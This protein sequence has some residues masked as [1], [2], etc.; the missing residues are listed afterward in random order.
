MSTDAGR[1][2]IGCVMCN[3]VA[4]DRRRRGARARTHP[5]DDHGDEPLPLRIGA[6]HGR[7]GPARGRVRRPLRRRRTSRSRAAQV[8]ALR[9][10]R[11]AYSP[12]GVNVGANLGKAAGAGVP[13]HLHVHVLPRWNGD[14][15]FMTAVGRG[16]G[17]ARE[18]ADGLR[19]AESGV[20]RVAS[21]RRD[22]R[23]ERRLDRRFDRRPAARGSRRHRLRRA[24][25]VPRHQAPPDRGHDL[26][27]A[28]R[29]RVV[30]RARGYE[31]RPAVRRGPARGRSPRT[32]SSRDGR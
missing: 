5:R 26:P 22:R 21:D 29:A 24:V 11:A 8:R 1:D 16:P 13:G 18:P 25:R 19:Q 20:A 4:R 9:A 12:D 2:D 7:A 31:Q 23:P 28:R 3:L 17:A 10:I 30:G 32:T 14:T 27:R 6:P 15:N